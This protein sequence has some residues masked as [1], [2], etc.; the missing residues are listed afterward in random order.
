[1]AD[2]KRYPLGNQL[3]KRVSTSSFFIYLFFPHFDLGLFVC[4]V[5]YRIVI[6]GIYAVEG[7][8]FCF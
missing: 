4:T 1:M 7:F 8:H 5:Y 3:G 6:L 2:T